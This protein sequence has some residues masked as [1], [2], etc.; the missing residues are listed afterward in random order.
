[1]VKKGPGHGP[2]FFTVDVSERTHVIGGGGVGGD[3]VRRLVV[4][5]FMCSTLL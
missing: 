2:D 5:K 4:V 1:M 3:I